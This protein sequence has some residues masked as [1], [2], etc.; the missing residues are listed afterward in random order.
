MMSTKQLDIL[1]FQQMSDSDQ[2]QDDFKKIYNR[3]MVKNNSK[4]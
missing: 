2:L 4:S 3:S 1:T